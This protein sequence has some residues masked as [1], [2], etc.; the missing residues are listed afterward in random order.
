M[1]VCAVPLVC[2]LCKTNLSFDPPLHLFV[3]DSRC[4]ISVDSSVVHHS[5]DRWCSLANTLFLHPFFLP[6]F[7]LSFLP[8]CSPNKGTSLSS[9]ELWKPSPDS[10]SCQGVS[11]THCALCVCGAVSLWE[12]QL[13]LGLALVCEE[14]S[15]VCSWG[16]LMSSVW[17]FR[18]SSDCFL[19]FSCFYCF[20]IHAVFEALFLFMKNIRIW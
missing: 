7:L 18:S 14:L 4:L 6:R 16:A 5:A 13:S 15:S 20:I 3:F 8:T 17:M 19:V 9:L 2:M 10:S 12:Q 1:C 11:A